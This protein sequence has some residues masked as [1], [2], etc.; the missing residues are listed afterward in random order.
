MA[1]SLLKISKQYDTQQKCIDLLTQLK[2]NGKPYCPSCESTNVRLVNSTK[3][4][5]FCKSCSN[6]FSIFT[7]TIFEGTTLPLTSWF[8]IITL[9]LNAKTSM[10]AK[11]VQ[12]NIGCTYKTAYY[13][14]MRVRV[15]MLTKDTML[16]GIIEMDE[17]YF[18]GKNRKKLFKKDAAPTLS[19]VT[20]KRGRGT[21]KVS[22]VGMVQRKGQV[23][24]KV[25]DQL[26]KRN[27]LA[28]LKSNAKSENSLLITDGFKSYKEMETYMDRMVINHSK[29][30]VRGIAH[31]NTIEGFWSY[32]KN[33]IR[34][35]FR[36]VSKKYLPLYLV[37]FEWKFNN[38][39]YK[40]N[41]FEKYLKNAL[42]QDK[43]LEYYGA[44][45]A[46][47]VKEIVYSNDN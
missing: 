29:E 21:R 18:G 1:E 3:Q 22:V 9:M 12:R 40:G 31:I 13:A 4:R 46:K 37:E 19:E 35:S 24:T 2:W 30:Y 32:I 36:S 45:S 38:R 27:L 43:E 14:C 34:G 15:G 47:E 16:N 33:G 44:E 26:S 25:I 20:L 42:E 8:Q 39:F 6:Q 28:M 7:D 5:Y 41:E 23:K 17:S 11:E 10:S